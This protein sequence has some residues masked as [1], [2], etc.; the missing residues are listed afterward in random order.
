VTA[1]AAPSAAAPFK[2]SRLLSFV[3]GNTSIESERR[4]PMRQGRSDPV[5]SGL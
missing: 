1:A 3:M 2:T 5:W 4:S